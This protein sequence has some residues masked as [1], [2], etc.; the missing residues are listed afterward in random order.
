MKILVVVDMQNDF[1]DGALGTEEAVAILPAV[2]AKIEGFD[3]R[4]LF[5]R[6]T[7]ETDYMQTQEGKNLPVEHCIKGTD[8]WQIRPELDALRKEEAIDKPSF[9]SV[10]LGQ[11]LKAYDTYEEK[12]ESITLIGLCTDICVISN[13]MIIKA[14]LPETPLFVDA[15]CCAGVTPE[16]HERALDAMTVCQIK[17]ENR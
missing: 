7:H 12:I 9:G 4:V 10:A 8:G 5:T 3:G 17:I 11:L 15:E 16:S 13:A 2:K 6:D 14:Y 1:I